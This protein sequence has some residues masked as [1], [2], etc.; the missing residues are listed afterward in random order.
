MQEKYLESL[1]KA[2]KS[3]QIA[4][5]MAYITY[6][7]VKDKRLLLKVLE[8]TYKSL[9]NMIN[10]ILQYDYLWKKITLYKDP[11]SNFQVFKE[12]CAPRYGISQQEIREILKILALVEKHKRSPLEFQRKEKVVIMTDN[13]RTEIIDIETI[14]KFLLLSKKILQTATSATSSHK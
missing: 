8:Q 1:Q 14:K 11:K 3:L 12:K 4:D 13:L 6:P 10:A 7:I 9:I 5:H 2:T